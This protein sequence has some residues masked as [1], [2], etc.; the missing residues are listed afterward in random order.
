MEMHEREDFGQ[1]VGLALRNQLEPELVA[2]LHEPV[3]RHAW[4]IELQCCID[5]IVLQRTERKHERGQ[6]EYETWNW[7]AHRVER[8]AR[9]QLAYLNACPDHR[10][11]IVAHRDALADDAYEPHPA[12]LE[13]WGTLDD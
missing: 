5:A 12:D 2:I 7:G 4:A 9:T 11:A 13:L 3:N 6:P 1:I 10:A 8:S